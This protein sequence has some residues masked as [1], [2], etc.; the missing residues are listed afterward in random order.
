MPDTLF[1]KGNYL[2]KDKNAVAIVG[3]RQMSERGK[4][5]AYDFSF[6]LAKNNIT[7]ISGLALGIDTIAHTAALTANGRT[8]AVLAHGLDRI[9]P[10][11]NIDLANKIIKSGCLITKF[12]EGTIPYAKNFLA[13]NQLIAALSKAVIV[14]EGEKRSGSISTANHAANLGVEVFAIPG[15]PATDFLIENGAN[16]ATKPED[17]MDYLKNIKD[18]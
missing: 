10:K 14:I 8:I 15:S 5:L 16:I 3:S 17:I 13:R 1:I 9:Y 2:E 12:S 4:K 18:N 11:E 6:Y 7:I